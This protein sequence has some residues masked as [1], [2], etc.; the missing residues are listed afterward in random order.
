[1]TLKYACIAKSLAIILLLLATPTTAQDKNVGAIVEGQVVKLLEQGIA[2]RQTLRIAPAMGM[3]QSAIMRMK[4]DQTMVMRGQKL[5]PT[6]TPATQFTIEVDIT[7]IAA[8]GDVSVEYRCPKVEVIDESNEPS[9]VKPMMETLLKSM[10]GLTGTATVSNRGFTKKSNV[11]LPPNAEPNIQAARDIMK[12][13]MNL[14]SSPL[15]EEPVGVGAKWKVIQLIESNGMNVKQTT[16]HTLKEIKGKAIEIAIE[17]AQTAD[18]QELKTPGVPTGTTTKLL[19]LDSTGAGKMQF[20]SSDLF[21]FS[22]MK[23][24]SKIGM[25]MIAAGN[26]I[27]MQVEMSGEVTVTP[28]K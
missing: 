14:M 6:P 11:T 5:P 10:K 24:D 16:V 22:S 19:S 4:V 8:N 1:M 20:I 15:P 26:T 23:S 17:Q 9:P 21:P 27:P 28:A 2:P 18:A 25:E 13:W 3:K 7:D 12:A